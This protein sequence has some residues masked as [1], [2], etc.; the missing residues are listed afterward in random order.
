MIAA[1]SSASNFFYTRTLI[2]QRNH[3]QASDLRHSDHFKADLVQP[4][5]DLALPQDQL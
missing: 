4:L 5:S 1:C 2:L 3:P